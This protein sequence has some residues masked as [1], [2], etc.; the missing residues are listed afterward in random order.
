[1]GLFPGGGRWAGIVIISDILS[2]L[3]YN[4]QQFQRDL[5]RLE[6]VRG[7]RSLRAEEYFSSNAENWNRLRN[8][9]IDEAQVEAAMLA[10]IGEERVERMLDMG[11][12]TGRLLE[13]FSAI[14]DKAVGV[15]SSHDMLSVARST[16]DKAGLS[17]A[18][19]RQGDI[20]MLPTRSDNFDLVTIHQVLHYLDDPTQAISEAAKALAAGGRLLVID[21][22]P[23]NREE[24]RKEQAH[25]RL[26]FSHEQ[27]RGWLEDAGLEVIE[28]RDLKPVESAKNGEEFLTVT[29]WLARD[30]RILIAGNDESLTRQIYSNTETV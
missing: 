24:L 19:V 28:T 16:I 14:C 25:I 13:L 17:H 11:T 8:M 18:Q 15:D 1:M 2:R 12:G 7:K 6:A 20:T 5:A 27:M 29:L 10:M 3:D 21:F 22:A 30:R 23:H 4:D 26:G 9:H